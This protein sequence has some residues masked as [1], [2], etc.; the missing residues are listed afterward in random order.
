[1]L[2]LNIATPQSLEEGGLQVLKEIT[3]VKISQLS[4]FKITYIFLTDTIM[5]SKEENNLYGVAIKNTYE[6]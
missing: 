2:P 5:T 6:F 1:M 4:H 3:R